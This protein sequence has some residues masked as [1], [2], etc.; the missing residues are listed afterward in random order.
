MMDP[1]TKQKR[2]RELC[3]IYKS[4]PQIGLVLG[5]GVSC[6]SD[7]PLYLPMVLELCKL[8]AERNRLPGAPQGALAFLE[9]QAKLLQERKEALKEK[10]YEKAAQLECQVV[11][12]PEEVALFMKT[13]FAEQDEQD[14]LKLVKE[15]L[16]PPMTERSH[17]MVA[18][19]MFQKNDTLQ[20]VIC[21]CAALPGSAL[22]PTSTHRIETNPKVG[23][24][25]TTNYD[26]LVEGAF[27]SKFGRPMLKPVGRADARE[28]LPGRRVIPVYHI[29]G[30]VSYV[31]PKDDP[32][33][34]KGSTLVIAEKDYFRTFYDPLGF[35]SYTA[36]GFFGRFPCLFIGSAMTDKNLRRFLYHLQREVGDSSDRPHHFAILKARGTPRDDFEDAVLSSYGVATIW[37]SG[38]DE[39]PGIL[40]KVYAAAG[41]NTEEK[42][43]LRA[44]W[45]AL[46][47]FKW[48]RKVTIDITVINDLD[49]EKRRTVRFLADKGVTRAWIP[50]DMAVELDIQPMGR[51]PVELTKGTVQEYPYG[52]C[53]FEYEGELV[54][55]TVVIGP[56]GIEP[57]AGTHLLQDFRLNVIHRTIRRA[58]AMR[59]KARGT[60]WRKLTGQ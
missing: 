34:V 30:Y 28:A 48:D 19:A 51:V 21:F 39:I 33:G 22:A 32:E 35:G 56:S 37:I 50:E 57:I 38:Y 13:Y 3:R 7:V 44:N 46:R 1:K 18:R 58:R 23:G 36:M 60:R 27:G 54:N 52:L 59:A 29:H 9:E 45:E 53:K 40:K 4:E 8:A 12:E 31:P 16:Y 49:P 25:L 2:I 11:I 55:G 10:D 42:E 20:S 15:V 6:D 26:Y 24:I 17:K 47:E 14:F 5:A 41:K 43:A